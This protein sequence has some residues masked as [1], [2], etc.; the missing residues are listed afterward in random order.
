M[1][2]GV[3]ATARAALGAGLCVL[4]PKEDGSKRPDVAS[5]TAYQR[6]RPTEA[7]M[8]RWYGRGEADCSR[9]GVGLVC[10]AVSGG[11]ELLEFDD[12]E[13]YV[14]VKRAAEALGLADL[15]EWVELGYS[16]RIPGGG[17]HW[18]YFCDSVE[19][20][21]R[22][23]ARPIS[24]SEVK[25]LIE[26]RGEGGYVIIAPSNGRVHP[27]RR[28]YELLQGGVQDITTI[29]ADERAELFQLARSFDEIPARVVD[30]PRD[31]GGS[32]GDR[33]GDRFAAA[34]AW[35]EILEPHGWRLVYRRGE[36]K[37]WRRP[38]KDGGVSATVNFQDSDL[39][40]V[41]STSTVFEPQRGYGK[42]SVCALLDHGSDFAV[43]AKG[44][45][46]RGYGGNGTSP[47]PSAAEEKVERFRFT[48]YGNA[49][50]LVARHGQDIRFCH[51]WGTWLVWDGRRWRRDDTAAVWLMAKEPIRSVPAELDA[52]PWLLNVSN[53]TLD[54][55]TGEL[56]PHR[57]EDLITKLAPVEYDPEA[58][59]PIFERV[60]AHVTGGD[61][62]LG[63]YLQR[64]FGYTLTGDTSEE[65]LF[66]VIGGGASG[67]STLIE[68]F[69]AAL[70]DYAVTADFEAFP[71]EARYRGRTQ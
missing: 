15:V 30:E 31:G 47:P 63:R 51:V 5:W 71:R 8:L 62:A 45:V 38:G 34:V 2:P 52:D 14:E 25:V 10:G 46:G 39:L 43:A 29:T 27:S 37:F 53:G 26:T 33:P 56:R 64:A 23:A 68:G 32:P 24:D 3:Q 42:F 17:I 60:I 19:G 48:D 66:L 58:K 4:P 61:E 65:K 18:L 59:H 67:K 35:P 20:N 69:K 50:R 28:P 1:A 6:E 49:E 70:G 13:T 12:Y 21:T 16:E 36:E 54:L 55:R 57:R 7:D 41:F 44:L 22:L 11:L 40:Y 9:G